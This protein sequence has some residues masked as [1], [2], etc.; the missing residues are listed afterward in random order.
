MTKTATTREIGNENDESRAVGSKRSRRQSKITDSFG[1]ARRVGTAD[2]GAIKQ[3]LTGRKRSVAKATKGSKTRSRGLESVEKGSEKVESSPKAEVFNF[4]QAEKQPEKEG[5][6]STE[7]AYKRFAH[8]LPKETDEVQEAEEGAVAVR[9]TAIAV[10]GQD[11]APPKVTDEPTSGE[12]GVRVVPRELDIELAPAL[13]IVPAY[14]RFS[15]LLEETS[16]SLPGHFKLLDRVLGALD[17][18]C[19]VAG[20]RDQ[21]VIWAKSVRALESAVGRR[22]EECHLRQLQTLGA[23]YRTL[24]VRVIVEGRRV[25]SLA[26]ELPEMATHELLRER[27]KQLQGALLERV[28]QAHDAFLKEIGVILPPGTLLQRWH[29]RFNLEGVP[30][31]VPLGDN[32]FS[33]GEPEKNTPK[34]IKNVIKTVEGTMTASLPA[35]ITVSSISPI[36]TPSSPSHLS[37]SSHFMQPSSGGLPCKTS[38]LE[39]VRARQRE[40]EVAAITCDPLKETLRRNYQ[41]LLSFSETIAMYA[42]SGITYILTRCLGYSPQRDQG[43]PC[44][45]GRL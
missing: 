5:E 15:H 44:S 7:P 3:P 8:L 37:P 32:G 17:S 38:V 1:M 22:V 2:R 28:H 24:P 41:S 43:A 11:S 30:G 9:E 13:S 12:G 18:I 33:E 16:L 6:G 25:N 23:F 19:M 39:R 26:L 42:I 35:A 4:F 27:R 10:S 45:W 21:P 29:P 20:G 36:R 14:Q 40:A 34:A 31:I